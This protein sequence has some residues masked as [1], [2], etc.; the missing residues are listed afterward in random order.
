VEVS[1]A[2]LAAPMA[3]EPGLMGPL[4]SSS[5]CTS[6][7]S[8]PP[9]PSW[10]ASCLPLQGLCPDSFPRSSSDSRLSCPGN[11]W[12]LMG[13]GRP[14]VLCW[15][16]GSKGEPHLSQEMWEQPCARRDG[17]GL[18]PGSGFDA[19]WLKCF[20]Q[21]LGQSLLMSIEVSWAQGSALPIVLPCAVSGTDHR[22]WG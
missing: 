5:Q 13:C 22:T 19:P 6:A 20:S 10:R 9:G 21:L 18:C 1:A 17:G 2:G 4:Q 7:A 8:W 15:R 11:L 14:V 3:A 12:K 16:E